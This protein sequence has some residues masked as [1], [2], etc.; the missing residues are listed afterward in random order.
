[1]PVVLKLVGFLTALAAVF[2][3][4]YLAG[5]QS[6]VLLAPAP[7]THESSFSGLSASAD[8]YTVTPAQPRQRPGEDSFVEF[9]V[10][11]PDGQAVP[12]YDQVDGAHLH[13]VAFRRDLTGY[14]H[15][16][17]E[18]G[19]DASWWAVLNLTPGSWRVVVEFRPAQLGRTVVLSTDLSV[20]G[21][22]QPHPLAPPTDRVDVDGL[23]VAL[24]R[25]VRADPD[26]VTTVRVSQQGQPVTDIQ[27]GH[28][29]LA[30]AVIVRPTDL[31]YL[32]LHAVATATTGPMMQFTGSPPSP[33]TYRLF[34]EFYHQ[35]RLVVAPFT[36]AVTQ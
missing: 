12:G 21:D 9:R 6:S 36:I 24:T 4:S 29:A 19:E 27:P 25:G 31:G 28:G 14:Q 2:G 35:D 7:T 20:S 22:D 11:G 8:G 1:M 26:S 16:Y 15:V 18:P 5:T 17:P 30:H 23:T 34:V 13:L 32:H 10:T 33:G 3:V